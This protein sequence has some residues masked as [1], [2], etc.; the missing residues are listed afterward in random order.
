MPKPKVTVTVEVEPEVDEW[1]KAQREL[2]ARSGRRPAHLCLRA[3]VF[4]IT[5]FE[6]GMHDELLALNRVY[7][8]LYETQ[9][10]R[11]KG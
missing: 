4:Q 1:F 7:A 5:I 10:K 9:F 8:Q 6:R 3:P 2:P 11:E